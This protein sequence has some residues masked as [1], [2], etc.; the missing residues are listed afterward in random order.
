[1]DYSKLTANQLCVASNAFMQMDAFMRDDLPDDF[2]AMLAEYL[3]MKESD[4]EEIRNEMAARANFMAYAE[5]MGNSGIADAL[6]KVA[7]DLAKMDS[8]AL[9]G[10]AE[11]GLAKVAEK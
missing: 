2:P 9:R 10:I 11:G 5:S 3:A 7:A 4:R 8:K 6:V 1:M